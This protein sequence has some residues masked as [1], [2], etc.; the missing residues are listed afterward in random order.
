MN[1]QNQSKSVSGVCERIYQQSLKARTDKYDENERKRDLIKKTAKLIKK[2]G[3]AIMKRLPFEINQRILSYL[4]DERGININALNDWRIFVESDKYIRRCLFPHMYKRGKGFNERMNE[5]FEATELM[6]YNIAENGLTKYSIANTIIENL[7]SDC[8]PS[9]KRM[10]LIRFENYIDFAW[11]N[12]GVNSDVDELVIGG[13]EIDNSGDMRAIKII[14]AKNNYGVSGEYRL[15]VLT[16]GE[17]IGEYSDLL[18][19]NNDGSYRVIEDLSAETIYEC[20]TDEEFTLFNVPLNSRGV[21][22]LQKS[23]DGRA[24]LDKWICEDSEQFSRLLIQRIGKERV[25][26]KIA[27]YWGTE[28]TGVS[29]LTMN[30]D[31]TI[32]TMKM[33]RVDN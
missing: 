9:I 31:D 5:R 33:R 16:D 3:G 14:I 12:N 20:L 6:S 17:V 32:Y 18:E 27:D 28:Y 4:E 1:T 13:T 10:E 24:I 2:K 11:D 15:E 8:F 7:M 29:I 19:E 22:H 25:M 21:K 30:Y 26:R 23:E